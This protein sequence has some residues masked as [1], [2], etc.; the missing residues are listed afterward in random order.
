[1]SLRT[2]V[3][4]L[5]EWIQELSTKPA[6][7]DAP[8]A[9]PRATWKQIS[10]ELSL[11]A[12]KY[13]AAHDKL[14]AEAEPANVVPRRH[15][16]AR[17][18]DRRNKDG[19]SAN[20][21]SRE[22]DVQQTRQ[23]AAEVALALERE[24][25]ALKLR[26]LMFSWR[27][28]PESSAEPTASKPA[29]PKGHRGK[30]RAL[31]PPRCATTGSTADATAPEEGIPE[32]QGDSPSELVEWAMRLVERA[33]DRLHIASPGGPYVK[34]LDVVAR[35]FEEELVVFAEMSLALW[36][37]CERLPAPWARRRTANG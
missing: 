34:E 27:A 20:D 18:R 8:K 30:L 28:T 11:A 6:P 3:Q 36:R 12:D 4:E 9:L 35:A 25:I 1:M 2:E 26:A 14:A 15:P 31:L 37:H 23:T 7:G 24:A 17:V 32:P 21:A 10:D 5:V 13:G 19:Q 16:F 33:H 29:S 22:E